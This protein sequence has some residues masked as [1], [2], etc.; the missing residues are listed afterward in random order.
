M[1]F[2]LIVT[3]IL[4]DFG[5]VFNTVIIG[6]VH[7]YRRTDIGHWTGLQRNMPSNTSGAR[8]DNALSSAKQGTQNEVSGRMTGIFP[9]SRTQRLP[10]LSGVRLN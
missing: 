7:R 8:I 1:G 10:S 2:G 3:M 4:E 6:P 5:V 9:V